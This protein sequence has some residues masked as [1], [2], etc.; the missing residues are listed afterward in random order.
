LRAVEK[1]YGKAAEVSSLQSVL[2]LL[3][4]EVKLQSAMVESKLV[5]PGGLRFFHLQDDLT[6]DGF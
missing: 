1:V 2:Q 4:M 5:Y 6:E 3:N